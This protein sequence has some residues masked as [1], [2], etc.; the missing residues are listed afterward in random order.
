MINVDMPINKIPLTMATTIDDK[1]VVVLVEFSDG[2]CIVDYG[3]S[4][5]LYNDNLGYENKKD[6]RYWKSAESVSVHDGIVDAVECKY[7]WEILVPTI[8]NDGKPFRTR[9][10]RVWDGR[11]R[12][13]TGGFTI[14]PKT[15]NGEWIDEDGVIYIEQ[16]IPVRIMATTTQIE[17]IVKMTAK[18][19][20]QIAIIY[21]KISDNV[22]IYRNE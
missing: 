15:V 10:H 20:D 12:D 22:R 17:T 21:Y 9:F 19:Y 3:T 6:L 8:S 18:Y 5:D 7:M 1:D 13:I 2:L 4:H 11:V 16:T 14:M